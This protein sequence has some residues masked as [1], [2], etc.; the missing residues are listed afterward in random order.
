MR[1]PLLALSTLLVAST[2]AFAQT[3]DPQGA[4]QLTN[5]LKRYL[6]EPAFAKGII[7]V[8]VDG[9]A[10]K[11]SFD[12]KALLRLMP[13]GAGEKVEI[14]TYAVHV[15]PRGDGTWDVKSGP[16]PSGSIEVSRPEGQQSVRWT[17]ADSSFEGVYDPSIAALLSGSGTYGA[18][19][20]ASKEAKG[21]V[22]VKVDSGSVTSNG[23]KAGEGAADVTSQMVLKGF[24]ETIA[25]HENN[26]LP[27]QATFGAPTLTYDYAAKTIKSRAM[28]DLLAFFIANSEEAKLK[29]NQAD[30]K[31]RLTGVLPLW[32][33]VDGKYA[34]NDMTVATPIGNFA[35]STA[36]AR[37]GLD[38]VSQ[39]G[40]YDYGLKV[41]GLKVPPAILPPW[42]V[43][44]LP[45]EM[46]INFGATNLDVDTAVRSAIAAFDLNRDPPIDKAVGDAI[47]AAFLAKGPKFTM[48]KSYVKNADTE[49]T[50]EGDVTMTQEAVEERA[51]P[52]INATI[53]AFGYDKLVEKLQAAATQDPQVA[54]IFP[55]ALAVKGFGKTL[56]D[57]SIEWI[58]NGKPDGSVLVNGA[59]LKGPDPI[60]SP[61]PLP[62]PNAAPGAPAPAPAPQ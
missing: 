48:P 8:A 4:Q 26:G 5:D 15:K 13:P 37:V 28:L 20:L 9:D 43:S 23:A 34:F 2:S 52:A 1:R 24:S 51:K 32:Q 21:G 42:S 45:T 55:M 35:A 33:R 22:E 56:P 11:I 12:P 49:I 62:D 39:N 41:T 19:T 46:D 44:L 30:L 14:G 36:T 25:S 6:S 61:E 59:M 29:A 18:M 16:L 54:Q 57:G 38:G 60:P 31:T 58:V 27:F 50:V 17:V 53:H 40:T 3:V 47:A 7:A 10:Y